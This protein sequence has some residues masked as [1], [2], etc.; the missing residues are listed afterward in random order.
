MLFFQPFQSCAILSKFLRPLTYK[1]LYKDDLKAWEKGRSYF[2]KSFFRIYSFI[3]FLVPVCAVFLYILGQ[4]DL[5]IGVQL[6]DSTKEQFNNFI[7]LAIPAQAS[8]VGIIIPIIFALVEQLFRNQDTFFKAFLYWSN[9]ITLILSS[10]A[11]VGFLLLQTALPVT[12]T[13][14]LFVATLLWL[15]LNLT[16]TAALILVSVGFFFPE[17]R[18]K[19]IKQYIAQILLPKEITSNLDRTIRTKNRN[20]DLFLNGIFQIFANALPN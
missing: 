8:L 13:L 20:T 9:V 12:I 1:G 6:S 19:L 3:W 15:G 7:E 5:S 18:F 17:S 11:L 16:G 2:L 10:L 14:F 4:F